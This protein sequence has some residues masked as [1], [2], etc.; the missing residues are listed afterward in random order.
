MI[1]DVLFFRPFVLK[2]CDLQVHNRERLPKKGPAILVSTHSSHMDAGVIQALFP[3]MM[4]PY[5]RP[6]AA[7]D[8]FTKGLLWHLFARGF[9]RLLFVDRGSGQLAK[10]GDI[11]PFGELH[12]PLEAGLMIII[13]PQGTRNPDAGFRSGIVHLAKSYPH[14]PVIPI[15]LRGTHDVLPPKAK[16][17]RAGPIAVYVGEKYTF[18]QH[19]TASENAQALEAYIYLLDQAKNQ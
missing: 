6:S 9:M 2:K 8:H 16:S 15:L 19:Q 14:V 5:I 3:L 18:N 7:R 17:F 4:L 1:V 12:I 13:F 11:D 10:T